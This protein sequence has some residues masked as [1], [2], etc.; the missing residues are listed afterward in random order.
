MQFI[1]IKWTKLI[2]NRGIIIKW[3]ALY[4]EA[5]QKYILLQM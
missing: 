3:N 4:M 5:R 2:H 1:E